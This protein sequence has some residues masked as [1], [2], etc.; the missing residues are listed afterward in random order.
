MEENQAVFNQMFNLLNEDSIFDCELAERIQNRRV[1]YY[2]Q[3]DWREVRCTEF[4]VTIRNGIFLLTMSA[5][6]IDERVVLRF[7]IP[8]RPTDLHERIFF[9]YFFCKTCRALQPEENRAQH[10]H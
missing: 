3:G 4:N 5:E 10:N 6:S 7:P 1:I 8:H 9:H 2:S